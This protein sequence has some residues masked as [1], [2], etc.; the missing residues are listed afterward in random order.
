[1]SDATTRLTDSMMPAAAPSGDRSN[2]GEGSDRTSRQGQSEQAMAANYFAVQ[3]TCTAQLP[4]PK[5][6]LVNLTRSV[7][8]VL[9]GTRE[10][11]QLTRWVTKDVYQILL[12]R[13]VLTARARVAT[14]RRVHRPQLDVTRTIV[15][16]PADGVIEAVVIVGTP[17][18]S[19][20]V[21]IRLE[22]LDR[23]WRASAISIL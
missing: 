19:R 16:E 13:T 18:R 15:T 12:R 22:G 23:R 2:N 8:E 9:A 4:D 7:L 10:L 3:R 21:A 5:P 17:V 1:M 6:M 11:E 14:G 20:A